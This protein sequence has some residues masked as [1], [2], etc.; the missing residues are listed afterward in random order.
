MYLNNIKSGFD[1]RRINPH[2]LTG[3]RQK[4]ILAP[5]FLGTC[6]DLKKRGSLLLIGTEASRRYSRAG[7]ERRDWSMVQA[8]MLYRMVRRYANPC[9]ARTVCKFSSIRLVSSNPRLYMYLNEALPNSRPETD[10]SQEKI[11]LLRNEEQGW[12][13]SI[14]LRFSALS[15]S[16]GSISTTADSK[17][18]YSKGAGKTPFEVKDQLSFIV[19]T[20][21]RSRPRLSKSPVPECN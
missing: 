19:P 18:L 10:Q 15:F 3:L 20:L 6:G 16:E 1:S 21:P 9:C 17:Y 7:E 14:S 13:I 8:W 12:L 11:L 4:P 5:E 2:V